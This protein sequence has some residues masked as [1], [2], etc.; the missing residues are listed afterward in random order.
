MP[1]P[2]QARMVDDIASR[3][4]Q[5][6]ITWLYSC[7]TRVCQTLVYAATIT[8]NFEAGNNIKIGALTN[9]ITIKNPSKNVPVGTK[10]LFDLTCGTP[11]RSVTWES[12]YKC[13]YTSMTAA[14]RAVV[15]FVYDGT[16]YIQIGTVQ[17]L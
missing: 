4:T 10:V 9:N 15:E 17:E 8:P 1:V 3:V 16:N 13:T 2:I 11:G 6:W 14:K 5:P 7:Q 12:V